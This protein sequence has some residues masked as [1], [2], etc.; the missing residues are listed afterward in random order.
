M[1]TGFEPLTTD[2]L[3][4]NLD[5]PTG[6][7]VFDFLIINDYEGKEYKRIPKGLFF[8]IQPFLDGSPEILVKKILLLYSKCVIAL[9]IDTVLCGGILLT[10]LG[11]PSK[12]VD[13]LYQLIMIEMT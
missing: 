6:M 4:K 1:S 12:E 3:R 5:D 9:R 10:D 2:E 13:Q 11:F 7:Q 8:L